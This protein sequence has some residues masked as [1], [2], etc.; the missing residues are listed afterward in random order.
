MI[1]SRMDSD[2]LGNIILHIGRNL[3]LSKCHCF[4]APP[5]PITSQWGHYIGSIQHLVFSMKELWVTNE[6]DKL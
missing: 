6:Y 2:S 5:P 4:I 3:Q 1:E